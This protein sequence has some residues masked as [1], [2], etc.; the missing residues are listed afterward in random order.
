MSQTLTRILIHLVFSTKNR[1][2]MIDPAV[3]ADLFAYLGGICRAKGCALLCAGGTADHV[4]LLVSL[5]KTITLADLLLNLKRD[6]SA[7]L[8]SRGAPRFSWQSGY[9]AFSIGESNVAALKRY[10]ASQKRH[11]ARRSF[12][13]ELRAL[14]GRYGVEIDEV[15]A[16][17]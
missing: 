14:C 3:E 15:H 5:S 13:D 11:H 1:S 7:W 8:K 4:H 2:P 17:H 10:I 16:W 9:A 12:Q 6:S